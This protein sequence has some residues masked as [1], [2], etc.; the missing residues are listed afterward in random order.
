[1][2]FTTK[3]VYLLVS[4]TALRTDF[5]FNKECMGTNCNLWRLQVK[6]GMVTVIMPPATPVVYCTVE[7]AAVIIVVV[8]S[9]EFHP[10]QWKTR[11]KPCASKLSDN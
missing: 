9:A 7:G 10:N 8:W 11:F 4:D 1:M 2:S 5:H 3:K 6:V